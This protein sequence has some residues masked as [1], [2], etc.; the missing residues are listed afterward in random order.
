MR[1]LDRTEHTGPQLHNN[2]KIIITDMI[3][4]EVMAETDIPVDNGVTVATDLMKSQS[5]DVIE[6]CHYLYYPVWDV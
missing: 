6:T 4:N 5:S 3:I 1:R 2:N